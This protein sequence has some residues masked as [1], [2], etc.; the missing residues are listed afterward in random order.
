MAKPDSVNAG[1][2]KAYILGVGNA[3]QFANL[4]MYAHVEHDLQ[5]PPGQHALTKL[6]CP[7]AKLILELDNY[8]SILNEEIK[9]RLAQAGGDSSEIKKVMQT[10]IEVLLLFGLEKTFPC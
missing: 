9:R 1:F 8:I 7:P 3:M 5:L 6:F 2:D 4:A 10:P